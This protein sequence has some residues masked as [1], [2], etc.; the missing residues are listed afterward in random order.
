MGAFIV[1]DH[2]YYSKIAK[3]FIVV[4]EN[5][6]QLFIQIYE[7]FVMGNTWSTI[8]YTFPTLSFINYNVAVAA[9]FIP[10]F[11]HILIA[12]KEDEEE[13]KAFWKY[14]MSLIWSKEKMSDK[15]KTAR[16]YLG[17]TFI[18]VTIFFSIYGMLF[19]M[20]YTMFV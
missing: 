11:Q 7:T 20:F 12:R 17:F 3:V 19:M 14:I 15:K 10:L 6:L 16:K 1:Y 5:A 9:L 18:L 4:I 8:Q 13:N 2:L